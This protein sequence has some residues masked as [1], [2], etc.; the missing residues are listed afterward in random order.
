MRPTAAASGQCP[1]RPPH[2]SCPAFGADGTLY[3]T[4]A[5]QDMDAAARAAHPQAGMTF[6]AAGV[7]QG[8]PEHR[9][10]L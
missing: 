4:T 2:T 5:L 7:A 1:L 3:C 8:Q 6:A 9:V 10:R